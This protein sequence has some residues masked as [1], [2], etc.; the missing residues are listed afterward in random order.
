MKFTTQYSTKANE[1]KE[2]SITI[3]LNDTVKN[4]SLLLMD[5]GYAE[6]IIQCQNTS[7]IH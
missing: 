3:S 1:I 5:I 4:T 6:T 2:N 7:A